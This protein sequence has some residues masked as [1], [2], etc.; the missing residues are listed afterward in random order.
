MQENQD[1][2]INYQK[3]L[4]DV[5]MSQHEIHLQEVASWTTKNPSTKFYMVL[6]PLL[7]FDASMIA[8]TKSTT[9]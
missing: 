2:L 6:C 1:F 5:F 8:G 4:L 9:C 3:G 7:E